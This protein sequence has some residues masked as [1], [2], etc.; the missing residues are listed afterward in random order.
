M[1]LVHVGFF[2]AREGLSD[3]RLNGDC[4]RSVLLLH[5]VG[6][7]FTVTP[8]GVESD[9]SRLV[10]PLVRRDDTVPDT[11]RLSGPMAGDGWLHGSLPMDVLMDVCCDWSSS[12][13]LSVT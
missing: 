10:R 2:W 13:H 5:F 11:V 8:T 3:T 4:L 9:D 6:S 1:E 7:Q 12:Q